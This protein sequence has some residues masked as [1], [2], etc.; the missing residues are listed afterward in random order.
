MTKRVD[1]WQKRLAPILADE[2]QRP[3]FDIFAYSQGVLNRISEV[4]NGNKAESDAK[5][6]FAR[7]VEGQSTYNI[8]RLFLA[9][10]SLANSGNLR[11]HGNNDDNAG[12]RKEVHV[13]LLSTELERPMEAYLAPSVV[14][15]G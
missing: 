4:T 13:E 7:V 9:T 14:N 5:V 3:A 10:L 2:E 1:H 15:K 6:P 12:E 11:I 8:C